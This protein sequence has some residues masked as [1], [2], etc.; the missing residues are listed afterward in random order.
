MKVCP[1]YL[2]EVS[3]QLENYEAEKINDE[4]EVF[5]QISTRLTR[6]VK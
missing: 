3:I 6:Q 2:V 4:N 1:H 5:E